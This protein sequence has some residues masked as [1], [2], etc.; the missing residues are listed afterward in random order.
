VSAFVGE[1]HSEDARS[2]VCATASGT[3]SSAREG[4]DPRGER[5]SGSVRNVPHPRPLSATEKAVARNLLEGAGAPELEVLAGQLAAAYATRR[6]ECV[7]P[8]ISMAVDAPQA[9]PVSYSGKPVATAD[10]DGGSVMVWVE[11]GWLSQL[12][13][14]WWSDDAPTEF[15]ELNDLTNHRHG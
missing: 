15:P 10:Y 1:T 3:R 2:P 11:D 8:T 4:L 5:S 6:C 14:Y 12:E 7:G 9:K 13:I